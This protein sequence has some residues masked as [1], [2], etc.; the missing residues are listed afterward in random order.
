M[1]GMGDLVAIR[2]RGVDFGVLRLLAKNLAE[3]HGIDTLTPMRLGDVCGEQPTLMDTEPNLDAQCMFIEPLAG[4]PE[5]ADLLTVDL[6]DPARDP[7]RIRRYFG[8]C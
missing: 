3:H 5:P 8:T 7:I 1:R 4:Q 6:C 2:D